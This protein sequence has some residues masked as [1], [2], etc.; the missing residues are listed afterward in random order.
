MAVMLINAAFQILVA[1]LALSM[2]YLLHKQCKF[3]SDLFFKS[4]AAFY[5]A[6]SFISLAWFFGII[7]LNQE[8]FIAISSIFQLLLASIFTYLAFFVG[9]KK[10]VRYISISFISAGIVIFLSVW[11][12]LAVYLASAISLLIVFLSFY[13]FKGKQLKK[14]GILGI[15]YSIFS[16]GFFFF[17]MIGLDI[18]LVFI[19]DLMMIFIV[20]NCYLYL[21]D[22]Q[23][24]KR[25]NEIKI[26][27]FLQVIRFSVF[28]IFLVAFTMVGTLAMHEFGHSLSAHYYGCEYSAVIHQEGNQPHTDISCRDGKIKE[29]MALAG[30][31]LPIAAA[32]ILFLTGEGLFKPWSYLIFSFALIIAN[33]D[34]AELGISNAVIILVDIAALGLII[35][36]M[37]RIC[38]KYLEEFRARFPC[39]RINRKD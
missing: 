28:V 14:A 17:F 24:P 19:A 9:L 6:Y 33:K 39:T 37:S 20:L 18:R 2:I 30:I 34:F 21:K 23:P 29:E 38:I 5:L 16:I 8:I 31:L 4:V 1:F 10:A 22:Y 25:Y 11:D 15:I 7:A 12:L 35:W 13:L 3:Q 26:P 27:V 36:A 32:I